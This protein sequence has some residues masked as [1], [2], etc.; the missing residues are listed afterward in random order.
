MNDNRT[1][2][3]LVLDRSGSMETIRE[4]ARGA[5][6][7]A[8]SRVRTDADAGLAQGL[9]TTLSVVMFNNQI[10]DVLV[11]ASPDS[12][13]T[14]GP[15]DYQPG[16]STALLDAIGHSIDM[17]E[18]AGPLGEQDAALVMVISDG[19]ENS[20]QKVSQADLVE[21]MQ[22]LEA[23]E[24]W[25]FSFMMANVDITDLSKKM[26][27]DKSNYAS[28]VSDASGTGA[29]AQ[30]L[31]RSVGSYMRERTMGRRQ[32]KEFF[33]DETSKDS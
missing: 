13:K 22:T 6:N 12:I 26:G 33:K 15:D 31:S 4:P 7:E 11:N 1:R 2:I 19:H 9:Q 30:R 28:W 29:V 10:E 25:T 27:T 23:T 16:G 20:S 18:E 5:F 8:I 24:Q 17:L 21:R 3:A 32:K 14:L